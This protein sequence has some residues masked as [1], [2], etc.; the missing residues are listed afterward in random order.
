M[1]VD[2]LYKQGLCEKFICKNC[3]G[4]FYR[5]SK[6][7]TCQGTNG[8]RPFGSTTCSPKCSREWSTKYNHSSHKRYGK[9]T[10]K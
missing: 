4:V 9:V 5:R 1:K 3:G 10:K 7:L 8:L 6:P 2:I